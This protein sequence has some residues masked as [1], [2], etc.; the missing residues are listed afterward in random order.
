MSAGTDSTRLSA[1]NARSIA[2]SLADEFN[3]TGLK[4]HLDKSIEYYRIACDLSCPRSKE[5][6]EVVYCHVNHLLSLGLAL[7]NRAHLNEITVVA[8]LVQAIDCYEKCRD[9]LEPNDSLYLPTTLDKLGCALRAKYESTRDE[10]ALDD[11]IVAHRAA[12]LATPK[13]DDERASR[14]S[15]LG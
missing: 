7:Q 12:V 6:A 13:Q 1:D 4:H 14:L 8:D 9:F 11:S 2:D 3:E 10:D 15:N 5:D